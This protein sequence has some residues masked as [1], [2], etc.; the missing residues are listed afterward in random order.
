[1]SDDD[2]VKDSG[3]T[4]AENQEGGSK[5]KLPFL[6]SSDDDTPLGDTDQHSEAPSPPAQNGS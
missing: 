5:D 4:G 1:V 2:R 6:P 3:G